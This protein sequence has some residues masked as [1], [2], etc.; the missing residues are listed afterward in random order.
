MPVD[1][2]SRIPFLYHF[3][4]RR[5]LQLISRNLQLI[6][7]NLQL[8][9]RNLQLIREMGGLYPLSQLEAAGVQ[10]PRREATKVAGKWIG[11]E[12]ST[13]MSICASRATI[14][15][16]TWPGRRAG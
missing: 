1:P 4:D 14:R 10:I 6:S 5:N 12:T 16:N 8:I 9:S 3:T 13:S 15:W 11:A 7:R 2:L